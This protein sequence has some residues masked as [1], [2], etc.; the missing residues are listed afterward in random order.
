VI[1]VNCTAV[2]KLATLNTYTKNGDQSVSS[3]GYVLS[4]VSVHG[5][6]LESYLRHLHA[7][8]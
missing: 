4:S 3:F 7:T 5:A 6:I 1:S 8:W 2:A